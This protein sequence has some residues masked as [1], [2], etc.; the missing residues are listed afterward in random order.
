MNNVLFEIGVEELP[1]MFIDDA[2]KQLLEK[3]E[4]WLNDQRL[5][6]DTVEPFA[7]PRRLAILIKDIAGDQL[8][9]AEEVRGPAKVIAQD[10]AGNW[11]KAAI[12][13]TK[14]QQ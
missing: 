13:F 11:T 3:T 12:G 14:G 2:V 7:T 5:T 9:L 4:H 6:Y 8:P 10:E 1:A